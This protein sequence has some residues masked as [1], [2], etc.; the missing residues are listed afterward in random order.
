MRLLEAPK[1]CVRA[2][3]RRDQ[4]AGQPSVRNTSNQNEPLIVMLTTS[5]CYDI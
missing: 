1:R 4:A 3:A 2:C 5:I